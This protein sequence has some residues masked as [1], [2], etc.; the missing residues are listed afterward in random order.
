MRMFV[1]W[2]SDHQG[3]WLGGQIMRMMRLVCQIMRKLWL[4]DHTVRELLLGGQNTRVL[5]LVLS[6]HEEAVA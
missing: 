1:A 6:D 4:D 5:W 3:V 2:W